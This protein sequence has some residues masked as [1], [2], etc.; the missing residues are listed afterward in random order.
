MLLAVA[1]IIVAPFLLFPP[2]THQAWWTDV[3][4]LDQFAAQ[5]GEGRVYPRWMP[6]GHAGMGSPAFYFYPPLAFYVGSI[7]ALLGVDPYWSVVLAFAAAFFVMGASF[8]RWSGSLPAAA[9]FMCLP[10]TLMNLY[11]RGAL[12]ETWAIAFIP[13][14]AIALRDRRA[15]LL[16]F[17]YAGMIYS[18]IPLALL[19]SIFMVAPY[20]AWRA[21]KERSLPWD[22]ATALVIGLALSAPYLLPA[23][24]L[25]EHTKIDELWQRPMYQPE[26]WLAFEPWKSNSFAQ[27]I[28]L[29]MGTMAASLIFA[30]RAKPWPQYCLALFAVIAFGYGLWSLPIIEKVQFPFR[31]LPVAGF[32]FATAYAIS[33]RP[34]MLIAP[35]GVS[36]IQL[37]SLYRRPTPSLDWFYRKRPEVSEYQPPAAPASDFVGWATW[38]LKGQE[39]VYY[40]PSLGPS[41]DGLFLDGPPTLHVLSIEWTAYAIGVI[42]LAAALALIVRRPAAIPSSTPTIL[43]P[44]S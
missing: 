31:L 12:A 13:L 11:C 28:Y 40:F 19:A 16:A 2:Q 38:P 20:L 33:R 39:G 8:Y 3:L 4:W 34:I 9:V 18:H 23:L 26:N 41:S 27:F 22:A 10:Y 36:T 29:I 21:W 1:A 32:A 43:A 35:L 42:G 15:L 44:T 5:L 7:P 25:Q 24:S 14:V 17:S 30:W 6:E 37:F